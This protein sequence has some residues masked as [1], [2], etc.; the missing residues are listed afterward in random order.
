MIATQTHQ[1]PPSRHSNTVVSRWR[2]AFLAELHFD[3]KNRATCFSGGTYGCFLH[4]SRQWHEEE[5][6]VLATAGC[7]YYQSRRTRTTGTWHTNL[8]SRHASR[9][10]GRTQPRECEEYFLW[11][12]WAYLMRCVRAQLS[13]RRTAML[14]AADRVSTLA[15]GGQ[16]SAQLM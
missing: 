2:L 14:S 11:K 16:T 5:A 3:A 6:S 10:S 9:L 8:C 12:G 15:K 4:A 13:L 7:Q 1:A